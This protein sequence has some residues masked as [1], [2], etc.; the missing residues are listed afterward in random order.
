MMKYAIKNLSNKERKDK[1]NHHYFL[2]FTK[3]S[4]IYLNLVREMIESEN[5]KREVMWQ[6]C[7]VSS[8]SAAIISHIGLIYI[9]DKVFIWASGPSQTLY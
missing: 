5:V 7:F 2:N 8:E 6:I 4:W 3:F 1:V 9:L